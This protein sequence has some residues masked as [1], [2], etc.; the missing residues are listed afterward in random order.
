MQ[1]PTR[2]LADYV[3]Y[4]PDVACSSA[5]APSGLQTRLTCPISRA[6]VTMSLYCI[7]Y[8][9]MTAMAEQGRPGGR[10]NNISTGDIAWRNRWYRDDSRHGDFIAYRLVSGSAAIWWEDSAS[11]VACFIHGPKGSDPT[12]LTVFLNHDFKLRDPV[13]TPN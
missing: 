9:D 10:R 11:P 2:A 4:W 1:D 7:R 6:G 12:L 5:P 8:D 3:G 13:P